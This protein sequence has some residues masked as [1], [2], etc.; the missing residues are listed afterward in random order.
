MTHIHIPF[1]SHHSFIR[2]EPVQ[3]FP[4]PDR[5]VLFPFPVSYLLHLPFCPLFLCPFA[6]HQ[7]FPPNFGPFGNVSGTF[8]LCSPLLG[9][10]TPLR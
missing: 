5:V 7:S 3:C 2:T 6:F 8:G 10:I 9:L 1:H 4:A